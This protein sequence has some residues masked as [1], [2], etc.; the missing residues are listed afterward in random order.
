MGRGDQVLVGPHQRGFPEPIEGLVRMH[1]RYSAD[2]SFAYW[3]GP[4][5]SWTQGDVRMWVSARPICG[6]LVPLEQNR[7]AVE[8]RDLHIQQSS[9]AGPAGP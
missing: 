2:A 7:F 4:L 1:G 8:A 9:A 6:E 3:S 5:Q